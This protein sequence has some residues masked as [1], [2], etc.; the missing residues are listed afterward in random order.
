MKLS[1]A[2]TN[3]AIAPHPAPPEGGEITDARYYNYFSININ[4]DAERSEA[5][6]YP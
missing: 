5:N 3:T 1:V 6:N 4:N 2:K